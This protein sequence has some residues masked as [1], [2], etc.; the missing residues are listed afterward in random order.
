LDGSDDL[1]PATFNPEVGVT[2]GIPTLVEL[3]IFYYQASKDE[4]LI[5]KVEVNLRNYK[6]FGENEVA[7]YTLVLHY[8]ALSYFELINSFSFS[9]PIYILLFSLVSLVLVLTIVVFWV[10]NL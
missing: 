6:V 2:E 3:N 8:E 1:I 5:S 9:V 10:I 7:A 4:K